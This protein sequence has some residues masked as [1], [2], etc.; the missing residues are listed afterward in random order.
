MLPTDFSQCV[1]V[2]THALHGRMSTRAAALRLGSLGE[3]CQSISSVKVPIKGFLVS[4]TKS[5]VSTPLSNVCGACLCVCVWGWAF[6]CADVVS[7]CL[8]LGVHLYYV[9]AVTCWSASLGWGCL[10]NCF[11]IVFFFLLFLG[12]F[13]LL[14]ASMFCS[15]TPHLTASFCQWFMARCR[16]IGF[17]IKAV[18]WMQP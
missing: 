12:L 11:V 13:I 16:Q 4:I 9:V 17:V 5:H 10:W 1:C 15:V 8:R 18:R 7:L 14:F 3:I 2:W 6:P